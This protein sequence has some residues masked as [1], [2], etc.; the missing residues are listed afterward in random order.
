MI[1]DDLKNKRVGLV[2]SSGFFGFFAHAGCLKAIEELGIQPVGYAGTS[3]GAIVAALAASGLH[4]DAV[5]TI[6]FSLKKDDFWDPQPWYKTLIDALR[7][8]KGARGYLEG[9]RFN[10]LIGK[11][12]PVQKFEDLKVPCVIVAANLTKRKREVFTSGSIA[13]AV[14]A[15]GTIP[16]TFKIKN[17]RDDYFLDGGLVDKVPLEAFQSCV[18]AQI[19]IVHYIA[20][21]ELKESSNEF[22]LKRFSPTRAYRL[23][24]TIA[25][26]EYYLTQ[27]RH[28]EQEGAQVIELRPSLPFVTPD[29]LYLGKE[30]FESAYQ[31]T[32]KELGS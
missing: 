13:D 10:Q 15:S 30:A 14:Q 25:R 18:N 5:S 29:R 11:N 2:F 6:L 4:A 20:S 3:S 17:I 12:L 1:I 23:S 22:L 19:I 9:N 24:I 32:L 28:V 27:K 16:W 21:S 31:H 8:F 26:H 7:L